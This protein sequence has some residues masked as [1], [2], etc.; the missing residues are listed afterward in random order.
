MTEIKIM[1]L[2]LE[3]FKCHKH[4]EL[5]LNGGNASVYGR[6]YGGK[7]SIYDALLWL[8]F[9][10]SSEW[11]SG[12]TLRSSPLELMVRFWITML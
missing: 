7:S 2:V 1:K 9:D 4:F 12:K 6:N 10:K 11:K 3:N 8:L 5:L